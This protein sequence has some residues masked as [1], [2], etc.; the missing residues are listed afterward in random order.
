MYEGLKEYLEK[1]G[2][3]QP[4]V[5]DKLGV[6]VPYVNSV[7]SGRKALG[8][9]NAKKWANLF[10]LSENYLLTGVG[11]PDGSAPCTTIIQ[12]NEPNTKI[13][14]GDPQTDIVAVLRDNI[15]DL[16][17]QLA[18]KQTVIDTQKEMIEIL[19]AKVSDLQI[20]VRNYQHLHAQP[21]PELQESST[22][23]ND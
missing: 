7:L 5:A 10:G 3:N 1:L 13:Q 8:K 17:I 16:R 14:P 6:S 22:M 18:D 2:Y 15:A 21:Y 20:K 23:V 12:P 4:K 19:Q 9:K 11:S